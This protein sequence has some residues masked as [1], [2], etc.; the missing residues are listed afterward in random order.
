[1]RMHKTTT[2][3]TEEM[4]VEMLAQC[5]LMNEIPL[6]D[7]SMVASSWEDSE[8]ELTERSASSP[9]TVGLVREE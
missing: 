3:N 4:P 6:T 5:R 8:A 7:W 9:T 1:M 2:A